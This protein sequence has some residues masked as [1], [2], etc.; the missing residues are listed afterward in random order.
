MD[1]TLV[2]LC[3]PLPIQNLSPLYRNPHPVIS[4]RSVVKSLGKDKPEIVSFASIWRWF[5]LRVLLVN[6]LNL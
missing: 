5:S 6:L 1:C 3:N 4:N 2:T